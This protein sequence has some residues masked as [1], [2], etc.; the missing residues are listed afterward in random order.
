M[1]RLGSGQI[2]VERQ[3]LTMSRNSRTTRP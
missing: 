3:R 1:R 2:L